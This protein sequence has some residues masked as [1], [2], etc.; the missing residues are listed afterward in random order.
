MD[1]KIFL[2]DENKILTDETTILSGDSPHQ[3]SPR[4]EPPSVSPEGECPEASP[5]QSEEWRMKNEE[6][7]TAAEVFFWTLNS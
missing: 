3:T 1:E 2:M 4:G 6:F 5:Q 7:A